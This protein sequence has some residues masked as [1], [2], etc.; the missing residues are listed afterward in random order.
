[1]TTARRQSFFVLSGA[2]LLLCGCGFSPL[3]GE[4]ATEQGRQPVEQSLSSIYIENIPDREGQYVRNALMDRFYQQ[5]RPTDP[6]YTLRIGNI[7]ER[8]TNLAIRKSADATRAQLHQTTKLTLTDRLTNEVVLQRD[9]TAVNSY[10]ILDSHF[11][12]R[13][14]EDYARRSGLDDLARQAETQLALY[15]Q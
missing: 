13:V 12:T 4:L 15:F 6:V 3:Y 11:T 9:L 1:M 10:N 7:R 2:L 8:T 14:S 5:G